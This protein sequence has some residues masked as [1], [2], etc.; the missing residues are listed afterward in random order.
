M[1]FDLPQQWLK[2]TY[3]VLEGR[4]MDRRKT[5]GWS[6]SPISISLFGKALTGKSGSLQR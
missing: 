2:V 5:G 6:S 3:S 4:L 1:T